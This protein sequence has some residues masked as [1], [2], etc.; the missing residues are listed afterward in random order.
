MSCDSE[1]SVCGLDQSESCTEFL[2]VVG[3]VYM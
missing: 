1:V 2:A 3:V